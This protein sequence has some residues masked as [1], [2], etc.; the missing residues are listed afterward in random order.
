MV[1]K[2]LR[3]FLVVTREFWGQLHKHNHYCKTFAAFKIE[4][5]PTM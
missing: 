5:F 1:A 4:Y 3:V 2:V